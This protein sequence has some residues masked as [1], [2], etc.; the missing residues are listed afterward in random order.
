[1]AGVAPQ[2]MDAPKRLDPREVLRSA[3]LIQAAFRRWSLEDSRRLLDIQPTMPSPPLAVALVFKER[4][5]DPRIIDHEMEAMSSAAVICG[6]NKGLTLEPIVACYR[7]YWGI[8]PAD[9][10]I[11][12]LL[13]ERFTEVAAD[14]DEEVLGQAH[15][16]AKLPSEVRALMAEGRKKWG[17]PE[18]SIVKY[19]FLF[20]GC[21]AWVEELKKSAEAMFTSRLEFVTT[22]QSITKLGE[23]VEL[24]LGDG[25]TP[26]RARVL[27]AKTAHRDRM[28][29]EAQS[30]YGWPPK[31]KVTALCHGA[32]WFGTELGCTDLV[33]QDFVASTM[34]ELKKAEKAAVQALEPLMTQANELRRKLTMWPQPPKLIKQALID[35]L[36]EVL[37]QTKEMLAIDQDELGFETP[38]VLKLYSEIL[39]E[40]FL[41][42][43]QNE[44]AIAA[45]EI[46][47]T[48]SDNA[49]EE[50]VRAL[51]IARLWQLVEAMQAEGIAGIATA[52]ELSAE[53]EAELD[54]IRPLIA[55]TRPDL[56]MVDVP[57]D[58]ADGW[59][60]PPGFREVE[61]PIG[62]PEPPYQ[63]RVLTPE[64]PPPPETP[65]PD[66]EVCMKLH[67]VAVEDT[68]SRS[69]IVLLEKCAMIIAEECG[70]P[71]DW[72]THLGFQAVQA[73]L[74]PEPVD[75]KPVD[76]TLKPVDETLSEIPPSATADS[77]TASYA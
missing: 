5:V 20:P 61:R 75:E 42:H 53:F 18:E 55:L 6:R 60:E 72:I 12:D 3:V 46:R 77:E 57:E 43:C 70:I 36:Q 47:R 14:M 44:A 74:K 59:H 39:K 67:S 1:M 33:V 68:R 35:E 66:I 24:E 7:E 48:D 4:M 63:C 29:Y 28:T 49:T 51:S 26:L 54:E 30:N 76:E 2:A 11:F 17:A 69:E 15:A 16:R 73:M 58:I 23:Q 41:Q 21:N 34:R 27:R 64:P 71:R 25:H 19:H 50:E 45:Q 22:R 52:T 40:E 62:T 32:R 37:D 65:R 9:D 38:P 31:G 56:V 8:L 13:K 10:G